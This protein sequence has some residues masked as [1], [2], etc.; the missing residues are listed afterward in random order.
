GVQVK[1]VKRWLSH[2]RKPIGLSRIRVRYLLLEH[3]FVTVD[4]KGMSSEQFYL[5]LLSTHGKLEI[6]TILDATGV[7]RNNLIKQW[8]QRPVRMTALSVEKVRALLARSGLHLV[9]EPVR[10]EAAENTPQQ[11]LA[12]LIAAF[13]DLLLVIKRLAGHFVTEGSREEREQLRDRYRQPLFEASNMLG[14]L[15]SERS[16]RE[17]LQEETGGKE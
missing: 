8:L 10:D 1:A 16:L 2:E 11:E 4:F 3:G 9:D 17:Y 12:T 15:C 13:G 5:G 6:K 7:S 14:A